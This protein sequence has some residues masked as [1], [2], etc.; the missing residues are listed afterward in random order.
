MEDNIAYMQAKVL[1]STNYGALVMT[2]IVS[3]QKHVRITGINWHHVVL[4][5][6][7]ARS[8]YISF[9]DNTNIGQF[10]SLAFSK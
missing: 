7:E 6:N 9:Y 4:S 3:R 1:H 5:R 2:I 10:S 8:N